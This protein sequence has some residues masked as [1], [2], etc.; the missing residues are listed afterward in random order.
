MAFIPIR[1]NRMSSM[2]TSGTFSEL[3]REVNLPTGIRKNL[4]HLTEG[5]FTYAFLQSPRRPRSIRIPVTLGLQQ[6]KESS[7]IVEMRSDRTN[8]NRWSRANAFPLDIDGWRT[9]ATICGLIKLFSCC[10]IQ[11]NVSFLEFLI[12]INHCTWLL[13]RMEN[14][15][16]NDDAK[17]PIPVRRTG[18]DS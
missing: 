18:W 5:G 17:A 14:K 11:S 12:F 16:P 6:E 4:F 7:P 8:W 13:E 15:F 3:E 10:R 2:Q 1:L 9:V